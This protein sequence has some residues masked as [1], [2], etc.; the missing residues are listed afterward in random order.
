MLKK[1]KSFNAISLR[2]ILEK[3]AIGIIIANAVSKGQR[4]G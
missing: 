3:K 1:V 4:G 2:M